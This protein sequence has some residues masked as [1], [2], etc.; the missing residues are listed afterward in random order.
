MGVVVCV[1]ELD[2]GISQFEI[3]GRMISVVYM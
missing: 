3:E 2:Q 1:V